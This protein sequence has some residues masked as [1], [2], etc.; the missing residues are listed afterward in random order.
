MGLHT[1]LT[2]LVFRMNL[3]NLTNFINITLIKNKCKLVNFGKCFNG[4]L[5]FNIGMN[6]YVYKLDWNVF[7]KILQKI[8][9]TFIGIDWLI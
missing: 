8:K 3:L 2:N 6:K 1:I 5:I 7:I 9:L 4:Y